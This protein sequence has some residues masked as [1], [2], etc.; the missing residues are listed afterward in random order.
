[1]APPALDGVRSGTD[2][3]RTRRAELVSEVEKQAGAE[4]APEKKVKVYG[5]ED[6]VPNDDDVPTLAELKRVIPDDCFR[7]NLAVSLLYVLQDAALI[8]ALL[9]GAYF[10]AGSK[11][12]VA[13]LPV[14]W[15]FMGFMM[16]AVFVLGHDC[17][18]GS[19]S[20]Y[21]A[22][23]SF[24][25]HVL[26]SMILVPFH[27]WRISH[28]KHHKNTGNFEKDEIFYPMSKS[29][30]DKLPTHVRTVYEETMFLLPL[31]Y[32][33]YLVRGY[34]NQMDNHSH[35]SPSSNLFNDNE[36][37]LIATSVTCWW[38]MM[39]FLSA[40]AVKYGA[41]FVVKY[42][43]T[44]F[45]VY[46]FWLLMVTF[47]HHTDTDTVWYNT[48]NWN[49]VKGNLQS[50]DRVYGVFEYFHHDIGTHVVHHLFP[51]IPHYK[52]RRANAALKPY[53]GKLHKVS[54]D[55]ILPAFVHSYNVFSENVA[56][57]DDT[58]VYV[59]GSPASSK[60]K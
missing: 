6:V 56:I 19:F 30:Y 8:S 4:F 29:L 41:L 55:P 22:V 48:K 59:F 2:G 5:N 24:V 11:Y 44:P 34:G 1:M 17:G 12:E 58:D 7:P 43:W 20:R 57:P 28:R 32:P 35:L 37:K 36:R 54:H 18:H 14:Y 13:Y 9:A 27:S 25:G 60:T 15:F 45:L 46:C 16:W 21:R 39:A 50:I 10:S 3:V 51:A 47:L 42:Y 26:H 52:L 53:L 33:V 40:L 49:Y 31:A 38:M 23:N